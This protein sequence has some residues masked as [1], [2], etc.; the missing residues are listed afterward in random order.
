M[1]RMRLS[2]Q[3]AGTPEGLAN[4]INPDKLNELDRLILKEAFRQ[5]KKLQ[6]RLRMEYR[7]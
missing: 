7:L 5:A 1:Q 4:R 2:Q 6:G 3:Q